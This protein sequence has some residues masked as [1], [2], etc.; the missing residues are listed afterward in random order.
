MSYFLIYFNYEDLFMIHKECLVK[1]V[2]QINFT[3]PRKNIYF[4][5]F[6]T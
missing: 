6:Y 1:L 3:L 4:V 5:L 2:A